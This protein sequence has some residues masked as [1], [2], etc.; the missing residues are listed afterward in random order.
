MPSKMKLRTPPSAGFTLIELMVTVVIA[1]I[2]VTVAI[3]AYTSQIR[4]SRRT[5]ARTAVLDL[6]SRE[7][8]FMSTQNSYTASATNLGYPSLPTGIGTYYSLG[9]PTVVAATATAP[10]T[11]TATATPIAGSGQD[12]DTQCA[13]FTVDSTGKQSSLNS[14]GADSTATCWN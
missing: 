13:S 9:A 11:F 4:K 5:E 10:A 8:R 12:K 3:P 1:T 14:S 2:L 7:E 6:A